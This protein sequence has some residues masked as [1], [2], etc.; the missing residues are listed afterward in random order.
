MM[1]NQF[2]IK[3]NITHSY[4]QPYPKW[5]NRVELPDRWRTLDFTKFTEQDNVGT[6]EHVSRYLAQL[7]D[8]SVEEAH[9]VRFFSLSLSRLA[10]T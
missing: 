1:E 8:A 4:K 6:M 10:F 5:F 2:G 9:R 7:G 3:R